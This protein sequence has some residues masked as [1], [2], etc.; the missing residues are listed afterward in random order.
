[1]A[2]TKFSA[3]AEFAVQK[4]QT[5]Y[6][7]LTP[8]QLVEK[9]ATTSVKNSSNSVENGRVTKV[10][11]D[12][13]F[14][15]SFKGLY[16]LQDLA[17]VFENNIRPN[18]GGASGFEQPTS[19]LVEEFHRLIT[20]R[21]DGLKLSSDTAKPAP[22]S[23]LMAVSSKKTDIYN[24]DFKI[25][26]IACNSPRIS[27]A[28]RDITSVA[29]FL[30]TIPTMEFSRAIPYLSINFKTGRNTVTNGGGYMNAPTILRFLR[31]AD[32]AA[33]G[34]VDRLML[35][36]TSNSD[37]GSAG[38]DH[39]GM[40]IF[41]SPIS[42]TP[43]ASKADGSLRATTI[44][45][46]NRPI[47]SIE[48]L[49]IEVIPTI[50]VYQYKTAALNIILHD[51]SR[52]GEVSDLVRPEAFGG[53]S[54]KAGIEITYG[55][56]HPDD[57]TTGNVYGVLLN[58]MRVTEVFSIINAK[59]TFTNEGQVKI[60]LSLA[61]KGAYD[62]HRAKILDSD[63]DSEAQQ[64]VK[65]TS[66]VKELREQLGLRATSDTMKEVR[67]FQVLDAAE[68]AERPDLKEF[69]KK[70]DEA[71]KSLKAIGDK[72]G[73]GS[74]ANAKKIASELSDTLLELYTKKDSA[75]AGG[76]LL[77][78]I[79][80]SVSSAIAGR[81]D[82]LSRVEDPFLTPLEKRKNGQKLPWDEDLKNFNTDAPSSPSVK[83]KN[84]LV[85][86][87]ALLMT[88]VG[89]PM[90]ANEGVQEVQFVFHTFNDFA[91]RAGGQNLSLFPIDLEYF[92]DI[93]QK[94]A[95]QRRDPN[96]TLEEFT[97]IISDHI[98]NNPRSVGYG[99][100]SLYSV[101]NDKEDADALPK[102]ELAKNVS[103][104][105]VANQMTRILDGKGGTFKFPILESFVETLPRRK[106]K[107]DDELP[108][109][110]SSYS[111]MRI[112]FYDKQCTP[113]EPVFD[114]L[115]ASR[116]EQTQ[117]KID[118]TKQKG[119]KG[120]A[121][122]LST[123]VIVRAFAAYCAEVKKAPNAEAKAKVPVPPELTS[124]GAKSAF[125]SGGNII[126]P[127]AADLV[128]NFIRETV[129]T[130][131]HGS[132]LSAVK[133]ADVSTLQDAQQQAIFMKGA[134]RGN[135]TQ[136]NGSDVGGLPVTVLP[137]TV[138]LTTLGCPLLALM[139]QFFVDFGTGTSVDNVYYVTG[140][141]HDIQAGKFE[142]KIKM[143][144][145][146]A[147]GKFKPIKDA[148]KQMSEK[149]KIDEGGNT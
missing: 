111:I 113:Y 145:G 141:S 102:I 30:N 9:Y 66:R 147:Y 103:G 18:S 124:A 105:A 129:P 4:L 13:L 20:L 59:F 31:G 79:D 86:L 76:G 116:G 133:S 55:W 144:P 57:I 22:L 28:S 50:G 7:F 84:F 52:L 5:Y 127:A 104:E 92:K 132:N 149:L 118:E 143:T 91:G 36:A 73:K 72:S 3:E 68:A 131:T 39:M 120:T 123:D 140:L 26:Y 83:K 87:G 40:E 15:T 112:H 14:N 29:A 109:I 70:L 137:T 43:L 130:I 107:S 49:T 24:P 121:G 33:P 126:V 54:N 71:L 60:N 122:T 8:T 85:S 10:I 99:M 82:Y 96:F 146:E 46:P 27:L 101:S 98:I 62:L 25:G 110:D 61:T 6:S 16:T 138:N 108:E 11:M 67:V 51:K 75:G 44:N 117:Q 134:A 19:E 119:D 78:K 38:F 56:S 128:R 74:A 65:L 34:T 41:T 106:L 88:F 64:L 114:L 42:M 148:L 90:M 17:T 142:T 97:R 12:A 135:P 32:A 58:R 23:K 139:Q 95:R 45:D 77:G 35:D 80:R 63:I 81:F 1:M 94:L 53:G 21:A 115:A 93:F 69:S 47:M 125:K 100:R 2:G 48:S 89:L 37:V 136:P